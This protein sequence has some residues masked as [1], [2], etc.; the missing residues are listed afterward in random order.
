MKTQD[1]GALREQRRRQKTEE[2]IK[3]KEQRTEEKQEAA[4]EEFWTRAGYTGSTTGSN[5]AI[6][7]I[8]TI[9]LSRP[10]ETKSKAKGKRKFNTGGDTTFQG[11]KYKSNLIRK[12]KF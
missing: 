9:E 3:L 11:A 5:P 10:K 6:E 4:S 8:T 1:T 2:A 7:P 12:G